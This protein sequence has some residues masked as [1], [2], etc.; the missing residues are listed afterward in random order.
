[1][2]RLHVALFAIVVVLLAHPTA[3]RAVD[4]Q[5]DAQAQS[6]LQKHRDFVGWQL[7]DGTFKTMRLTRE[8]TN[9][10]GVAITRREELRIGLAYRNTSTNLRRNVTYDEGFTGNIF[11]N[12]NWNGFTTPEYGDA[13]KYDLTYAG[14]FNEG[15]DSLPATSRGSATVDGTNVQIVRVQVPNADVVDL[16]VDPASGAFV[17]AVIDPGGDYD[18]TIHGIEYKDVLPGKKMI[19]SF[20]YGAGRPWVYTKIEPNGIVGDQELHPPAASATWS[21]GNAQP[22]PIQVKSDRFYVDAIINGVHG[23]FILDTGSSEIY[24]TQRFASKVKLK[25]LW[26]ATTTGGAI[27][28]EAIKSDVVKLD[29]VTI[30]GN[31]LSNAMAELNRSDFEGDEDAP[32]G[33]IGFDLFGGAVVTL[34]TVASTMTI[35]DPS[36]DVD[37]SQGVQL[38]VDL[39]GDV[40]VVPMK[41]NGNIDVRAI[42]D[43]GSPGH[44]LFSQELISQHGL[45]MAVD[46]S[47]VGYL[48]SHLYFS[49]VAGVDFRPA[50]CG[51]IDS[52]ALG[53]IV[54][55]GANACSTY[56][57][58][59][60]NV[61]VG[62]DF[63]KHFNMIFDYPHARLIL[64]P[65]KN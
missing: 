8:Y 21:F 36:T 59:G 42:L 46:N 51:H 23:R 22:F 63:L 29:S 45:R 56:D 25:T 61:L 27:G 7:G 37:V 4:Q 6:L 17:Q 33:L 35:R 48:Q 54:Y 12:T 16:Y 52:L 15:L 50:E 14:F 39:S 24:L 44:V 1:M 60:R 30:G 19:H 26:S 9:D 57:L 65:N 55:G 58:S 64:I 2:K 38:L 3:A 43:S 34:D 5:P 20:R 11:W 28:S 53:P 10:K 18:T 47:E 32:D 49:G 41:L 31:T 40:P 62:F 13:A